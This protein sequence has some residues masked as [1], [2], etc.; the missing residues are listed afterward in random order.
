ML[1][2]CAS[3]KSTTVHGLGTLS[4]F[5]LPTIYH[6]HGTNPLRIGEGSSDRLSLPH[7]DLGCLHSTAFASSM[8]T[9]FGWRPG[10]SNAVIPISKMA[11]LGDHQSPVV[12][13][14][15]LRYGTKFISGGWPHDLRGPIASAMT[16][17][18]VFWAPGLEE[19][20][21]ARRGAR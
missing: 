1:C 9:W 4:P 2:P 17:P 5:G 18:H 16:R 11:R 20:S 3:V 19:A 8:S 15:W 13:D 10:F 12:H 14:L 7:S 21:Y 6:N